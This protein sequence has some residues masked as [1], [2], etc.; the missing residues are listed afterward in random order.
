MSDMKT[1]WV[2]G[3]KGFVGSEI[4]TRLADKGYNVIGTDIEVSI[5]EPER[6]EAFAQASQPDVIINAAGIPR[7]AAGLNNR[8]K[9]YETNTLGAGNI[10]VVANSINAK[11]VQISTDDV[12]PN[13]LHEPV[14]EFDNP[15][16]EKPYGKSKRAGEM[17]IRDTMPN[18]LILRTT[19]LYSVNGG[20][21]KSM[22]DTLNKGEVVEART[23][24]YNCPTSITTYVDFMV[25]AIEANA[26]G[27]LHITGKGCISRYDFVHKAL[28][29][30]GY[31]ASNWVKPTTDLVTAEQVQL[32]SLML[33]M[34]GAELPN[35]EDDLRA[36]LT[37]VGLAK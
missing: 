4:A 24:Q 9:A 26:T 18:H 36:Y 10:A 20:I 2:T 11:L 30:M 6:L 37:E 22:L 27:I 31:D 14:N 1:I 5:C 33:E 15:H 35:W 28:E 19:W 3:A 23:D 29:I 25:K 17:M 34:F 32:E 12:F 21:L 16:P 13:R 8:I 7:A